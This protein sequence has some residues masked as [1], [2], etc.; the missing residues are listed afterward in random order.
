MAAVTSDTM[1][2]LN[3]HWHRPTRLEYCAAAAARFGSWILPTAVASDECSV[4]IACGTN[5][6]SPA[7]LV[8]SFYAIIINAHAISAYGHRLGP[9]LNND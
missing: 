1:P 8:K 3:G 7:C 9:W 6:Q 5:D 2:A 4:D